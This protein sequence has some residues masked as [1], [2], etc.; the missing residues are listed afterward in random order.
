MK[1]QKT[2]LLIALTILSSRSLCQD[3]LFTQFNYSPLYLNPAF[4]GCGK[5]NLRISGLTKM[6]WFNLYK[7]YKYFNGAVD[8]SIYDDNLRNIVNLGLAVNHASKG[9]LR[10]TNISGILGRSFGTNSSNCSNWFLSMALQAGITLGS[11]N[12]NDFVFIDQLDQNGITGSPSQVD[13]F[14]NGTN[15][16]YFDMSAGFVYTRNDFMIGGAVH[17]INEP[18]VSFNGKPEN[19]RLPKKITTHM[20]ILYENDILKLKPTIIAQIQGESRVLIGGILISFNEYP[21]ELGCWYRNNSG[22]SNNNAFSVGFTWKWGQNKTGYTPTNEYSTK[23]GLSYDAEI[24]KPGLYTTH[25]SLELGLQRD[26]IINND[27]KCPTASSGIC[28]YR[29][30]WEFF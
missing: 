11:V 8:R 15:K 17:H 6:Q 22:L 19:G 27:I 24:I 10:N 23:A 26:I 9:Y 5:N 25:G 1:Y 28:S 29:F 7:P 30:P 4:T 12:N 2:L 18:Y 16:K 3:A 20:S 21:I 13:L 14:V